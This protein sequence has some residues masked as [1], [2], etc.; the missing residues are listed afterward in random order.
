[1][2]EVVL[3]SSSVHRQHVLAT[4]RFRIATAR[5]PGLKASTADA[6]HVDRRA[7]STLD[8]SSG[9]LSSTG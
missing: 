7:T 8:G 5:K 9:P 6:L 2:Q 3:F 1:M 4:L